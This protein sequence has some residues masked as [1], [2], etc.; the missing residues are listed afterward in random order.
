MGEG[1]NTGDF[2]KGEFLVTG[3]IFLRSFLRF[4]LIASTIIL[5]LLIISKFTGV[6]ENGVGESGFVTEAV[7]YVIAALYYGIIV[8][9]AAALIRVA[10]HL[11]GAS[12]LLPI[13]LIPLS[14]I[15]AIYLASDMIN[16]QALA[17]L[18]ALSDAISEFSGSTTMPAARIGN[19]IV[20]VIVL[21]FLM[22]GTLSALFDP[23][24]LAELARFFLTTT[25]VVLLGFLP[26]AFLSFLVVGIIFIKR[27]RSRYLEYR[28]PTEDSGP[29]S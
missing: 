6:N 21:P 20:A 7:I 17:V 5:L 18:A 2:I 22:I 28:N 4:T 26:A 13:I 19:P 23:V 1:K 16:E 3:K 9:L 29:T 27:M 12:A 24:V 11:F 8:G 10:F 25:L 15:V 14:M